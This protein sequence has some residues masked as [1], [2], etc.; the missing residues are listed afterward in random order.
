MVLKIK[1]IIY[2]VFYIIKKKLYNYKFLKPFKKYIKNGIYYFDGKNLDK[3]F[4]GESCKSE[5]IAQRVIVFNFKNEGEILRGGGKKGTYKNCLYSGDKIYQYCSDK[6]IY[7]M[8]KTNYQMYAN[9]CLYPYAKTYWY[10]DKRQ[11]ICSEFVFGKIYNDKEHLL[12]WARS[13]LQIAQTVDYEIREGVLYYIQHGD[14]WFENIIWRNDFDFVYIDLDRLGLWPAL[15]D[16]IYGLLVAFG[17]DAFL[18]IENNLYSYIKKLFIYKGLD[19]TVETLDIYYA[20]FINIWNKKDSKIAYKYLKPFCFL[21]DRFYKT[22]L[23]LK[24]IPI[25][26]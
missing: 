22:K 18:I 24:E 15:Y 17:K 2:Q 7:K 8:N 21:D 23:L 13:V 12:F 4:L 10:N 1:Q 9:F 11:M 3:K 16:V 20:S 26:Y 6:S 14:A 19:F 5:K 25:L